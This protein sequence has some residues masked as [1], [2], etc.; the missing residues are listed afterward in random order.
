MGIYEATFN[1]TRAARDA[2]LYAFETAGASVVYLHHPMQRCVRDLLT[3]LKHAVVSAPV[4]AKVGQARLG[5][6]GLGL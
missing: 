3:G 4:Q 5:E 1:A 2:T 6:T